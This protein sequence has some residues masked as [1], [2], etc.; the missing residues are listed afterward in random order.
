MGEPDLFDPD[1]LRAT[2]DLLPSAPPN[3]R[4]RPPRHRA[5]EKF[6]KGPIPWE[7]LTRAA[8]L[9]G[10]TLLVA[11]ALWQEAGMRNNRAVHFCLSSL[12]EFGRSVQAARRG[13]RMLET[14]GLVAVRVKPGQ[15][16]DVTILDVT[17]VPPG[18]GAIVRR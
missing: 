12:A 9:P 15:C 11:L 2:A 17:T 13:L 18:S 10:S 7:W 1:R 5:G 3:P 6:L 14:A 8:R 16:L 4:P